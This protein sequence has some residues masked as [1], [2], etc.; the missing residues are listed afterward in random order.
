MKQNSQKNKK[1]LGF[2]FGLLGAIIV[3]LLPN[4]ESLSIEAQRA[5]AVFVWMGVWWATEAVP[6]A[7]TALIPLVC[8][9]LLGVLDIESTAAPYANKNIYLFLGGFFLSIAIQKSNLHKRIA[10]N[11]LKYTGT[12]GKSIIGGFMLSAG[13]LSMWIMNTSTTIMLLPIGL[14]IIAVVKESM[15]NLSKTDKVNFQVA[16]LLGI[17]YGANIGGMATLIG[18][19]PNMALNGFMEDN[20][21]V[22][23]SFL[24]WMKVGLPLSMILLPI[25]WWTLTTVSFPVNFKSSFETQRTIEN[26]R[27]DLGTI[28]TPEKRVFIIFVITALLWVFRSP[29]DSWGINKI[30]G[31]EGLT[32]PGIAMLCGLMLFLTPNGDN[33]HRNLL[34]WKDAQEGIPWGILILFG[35]GL[36]LAFA[37]QSTGL[38]EWL[39]SLVPGGLNTIVLVFIFTTLVIFLTELT[40]NLATTATFLPIVAAIALQFDFNPLLLTASVALAASCAFML[41]VATPPNAIVFGSELISVPQMM[42][43]GILINLIAIILVSLVGIYLIP[44]FLI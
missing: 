41:P 25:T 31:L 10:L 11:I 7:V 13:L 35:G 27:L 14:A 9:P 16:L 38:A 24:D 32:D 30:P 39:G 33:T 28:K 19:A 43:A 42:K 5:A 17:A 4:P 26:M 1:N 21:N 18:T 44:A 37:A 29:S 3:L 36:S 15:G 2:I 8:F 34:E 12:G 20:Y 6:I 23:I 40:S 22:S